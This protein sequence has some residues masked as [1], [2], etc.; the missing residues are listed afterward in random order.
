VTLRRFAATFL[1]AT[2]CFSGVAQAEDLRDAL[3]SVYSENPRLLAERARLRE[4]DE[5]YVQAR[6]QGRFSISGSASVTQAWGRFPNAGELIPGAMGSLSID[7]VPKQAGLQ[8]IQPLYQGGRVN[9]LKQQTKLG[10]L[11]AREN[12]RAQE[13]ALFLAAANAYV[14]V[15]RDE[16]AARIRRNNVS[17]LSRQLEAATAR[18]DVGQ[19]TRTD[20]AQSRSRMALSE[21][22]LAQAEAQ[23]ASS[24]ATYVRLV[25]RMPNLLTPPPK[26]ALPEDVLA[27]IAAARE[28]NP[29]LISAY[30]N[31]AAGRAAINVAKASG[32]PTIS[33]SGNLARQ[34]DQLSNIS[35]VDSAAITAQVTIPL[36]S[37][38]ANRS[39]VRQAE[40]AKTRLAFETRDA[41]MAIDESVTQIWAQLTAA[42]ATLSAVRRQEEAADIALEG[43]TLEQSVGTRDQLDVLNAEQEALDAKLSVLDAERNVNAAAF[44]L[45]SVIGVFDAEGI[46]LPVETYDKNAN[47]DIIRYKGL[48]EAVDTYVPEFAQRIGRQMPNIPRE[49]TRAI[50]KTY[51]DSP[52]EQSVEG[53]VSLSAAGVQGLKQGVGTVTGQSADYD[54]LRGVDLT[55]IQIEPISPPSVPR[56]DPLIDAD[57]DGQIDE[58]YL[59]TDSPVD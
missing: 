16:E 45:L 29:Q 25:G 26:F 46:R 6:A 3:I 33:L 30:F 51:A 15:R 44:N 58:I 34:R 10:V 22:G 11:A 21:A 24:R 19:G 23:L 53:V 8:I 32:R 54:D 9:A 47:L 42:R 2:A 40:H 50:Q 17:V 31:E 1:I 37:G 41:E 48:T 28:N 7:G 12:L 49:A 20:V 38:G 36:F 43:V 56:Y 39:R 4:I 35:A 57:N 13:N 5:S 18:F 14:D 27:A 59:P 55:S 52:I